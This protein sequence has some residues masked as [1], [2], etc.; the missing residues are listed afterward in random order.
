[1][2]KLLFYIFSLFLIV[3]CAS[4]NIEDCIMTDN[5]LPA[6]EQDNNNDGEEDLWP[7]DIMTASM[8]G[9]DAEGSNEMTRSYLYYYYEETPSGMAFRWND[10]DIL[11]V[12]SVG[13]ST[14]Q[15]KTDIKPETI[16]NTKKISSAS[17]EV[18]DQDI[19][20]EGKY[21]AYRPYDVEVGEHTSISEIPIDYTGQIQT[22]NVK[23]SLWPDNKTD[24]EVSEKAAAAHLSSKDYLVSSA[25]AFSEGG[26]HFNMKRLG[27]VI[28]FYFVAP[29]DGGGNVEEVIYDE[30][31]L[32][33]KENLF[34]LKTTM[35]LPDQALADEPIETSHM[36]SL[37]LEGEGFDFTSTNAHRDEYKYNRTGYG[38]LVIAYMMIAPVNL[39]TK[40]TIYLLG[41]TSEGVRKYYKATA[42]EKNVIADF[43][44]Q[45][46]QNDLTPDEPIT[47][48][49]ISVEEWKEGTTFSNDDG[50]GTEGW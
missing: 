23:M 24:Y 28:R 22:A 43:M 34:T 33:N 16:T 15:Q 45:W 32:V 21:Y 29:K 5:S 17:F 10:N 42:K 12:F 25:S 46:S 2:N 8:K 3:S 31:Q 36:V 37:S 44:H 1:M 40:S 26:I 18:K 9:V 20:Y 39:T 48:N 35:S 7:H 19:H 27:G 38:H 13:Y 11:G 14:N 47:F 50:K 49:A 30:I 6:T 41:R 4:D